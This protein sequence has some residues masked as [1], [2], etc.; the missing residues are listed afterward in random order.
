MNL[1]LILLNVLIKPRNPSQSKEKRLK[2]TV[3]MK[4][5]DTDK[6]SQL[7]KIRSMWCEQQ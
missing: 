2:L 5:K 7:E 6:S 4:E 1:E 3:L